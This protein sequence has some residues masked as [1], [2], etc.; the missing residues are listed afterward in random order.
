MYMYAIVHESH[1]EPG[2][3]NGIATLVSDSA[4]IVSFTPVNITSFRDHSERFCCDIRNAPTRFAWIQS[5][6]ICV[7]VLARI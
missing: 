2:T 4:A 6:P 5:A 3:H 1:G 7:I